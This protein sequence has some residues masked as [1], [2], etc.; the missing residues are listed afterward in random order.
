LQH[1]LFI[2]KAK[3][4][5]SVVIRSRKERVKAFKDTFHALMWISTREFSQRLQTFRLTF[6]QFITLA[7]LTAHQQACTMRDLTNAT[8]QDPPTMTGIIDRLVR[9]KLVQRTRSE[10]DRRVVLVQAT[11]A[12]IDLTH[13]INEDIM[14]DELTNYINLTDE[15]LTAL[16]RLVRLKLRL[17]IGRYKSLPDSDLETE[18]EKLQRFMSDPIQ[19]VKLEHEQ[20]I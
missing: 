13:Q 20:K 2:L 10:T 6:P 12:G 7:A 19:Y 16:E 9:M 5:M 3:K 14:N 4:I 18:L 15:D 17:Y 8:F 11:S 1:E